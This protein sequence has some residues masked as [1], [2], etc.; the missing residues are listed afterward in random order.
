[1]KTSFYTSVVVAALLAITPLAAQA[2]R[3]VVIEPVEY[4]DQ[5]V[6][7]AT[8]G[9]AVLFGALAAMTSGISTAVGAVAGGSIC[10]I[11]F[12]EDY[13]QGDRIVGYESGA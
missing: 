2:D 12:G 13:F 7:A 10:A 11:G 8:V 3:L 1:M 6:I 4:T 5:Q 9:C